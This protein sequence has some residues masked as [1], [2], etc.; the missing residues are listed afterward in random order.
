MRPVSPTHL[1]SIVQFG[2]ISGTVV[3]ESIGHDA[4][5]HFVRLTPGGI[6]RPLR[7]LPDLVRVAG[8]ATEVGAVEPTFRHTAGQGSALD[9]PQRIVGVRGG[10][11]VPIGHHRHAIV[12]V[13]SPGLD[14]AEGVL[15]LDDP[16]NVVVH[17]RA[18]AEGIGHRQH[19]AQQVVSVRHAASTG[20]P[21]VG[22]PP[23]GVE[24]VGGGLGEA[25]AMAAGDL[26]GPATVAILPRCEGASSVTLVRQSPDG[27]VSPGVR[28]VVRTADHSHQCCPVQDQLPTR[29][30]G[31]ALGGEEF[32]VREFD[33]TAGASLP[34][35]AQAVEDVGDH[36]A[37]AVGRDRHGGRVG[38]VHSVQACP[39]E[40]LA[41]VPGEAVCAD[42]RA[43]DRFHDLLQGGRGP[44]VRIGGDQARGGGDGRQVL[45]TVVGVARDLAQGIGAVQWLVVGV[46]A[47]LL[48]STVW[49]YM[50]DQIDAIGGVGVGVGPILRDTPCHPLLDGLRDLAQSVPG[51]VL[52]P[53]RAVG[54][55]PGDHAG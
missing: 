8:W 32:V 5:H 31:V 4:H 24:G 41:R 26:R 3:H 50:L 45:V 20:E 19:P 6:V 7:F 49:T 33:Q 46:V 13:V 48:H 52:V 22:P 37:T 34:W 44:V 51:E 28:R 9:P 30:A 27:V 12:H 10:H 55:D 39:H 18:A 36:E 43:G 25:E 14:R 54:H 15:H 40:C 2:Q 29:A 17:V 53:R 38:D 1:V 47:P 21:D 23:H 11:P 35:T 16:A 42:A